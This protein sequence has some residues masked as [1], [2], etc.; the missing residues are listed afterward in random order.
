[1]TKPNAIEAPQNANVVGMPPR[2]QLCALLASG[3]HVA[4]VEP[5]LTLGPPSC[6]HTQ[7]AEQHAW[8]WNNTIQHADD[9]EASLPYFTIGATQVLHYHFADAGCTEYAWNST[10]ARV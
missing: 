3:F 7:Q 4:P 5:T 8:F 6:T 9:P 1:M 10:K 2:V